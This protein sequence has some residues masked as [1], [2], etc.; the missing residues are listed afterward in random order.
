MTATLDDAV[1]TGNEGGEADVERALVVEE[2]NRLGVTAEEE[3]EVDSDQLLGPSSREEMVEVVKLLVS[4]GIAGAVSKTATA[5]LA[6]LTI[7]YQVTVLGGG[8]CVAVGG[9]G[10]WGSTF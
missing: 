8:G 10:V 4:G 6:R 7:L 9:C 1:L 2:E 5:P 3:V